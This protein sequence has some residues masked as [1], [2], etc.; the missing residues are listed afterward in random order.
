MF[1]FLLITSVVPF[2]S[3]F[4]FLR[5]RSLPAVQ[6]SISPF[7]SLNLKNLCAISKYSN[8]IPV[9]FLELAGERTVAACDFRSNSSNRLINSNCWK[10]EG[11]D[12]K[13]SKGNLNFRLL[14]L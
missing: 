8:V 11:Y 4:M 13:L 9:T 12:Q 10:L 3:G 2:R 5:V 1:L 14:C 7:F 6:Y